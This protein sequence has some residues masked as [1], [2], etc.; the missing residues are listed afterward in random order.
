MYADVALVVGSA[1]GFLPGAEHRER[2]ACEAL[3][4]HWR[5]HDRC[6]RGYARGKLHVSSK[7]GRDELWGIDGAHW[8]REHQCLCKRK[9]THS[10]NPTAKDCR[11][12]KGYREGGSGERNGSRVSSGFVRFL[13]PGRR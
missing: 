9:R 1:G 3:E 4:D 2:F 13:Q 7:P 5:V 12:G 6:G 10:P 8:G 11:M